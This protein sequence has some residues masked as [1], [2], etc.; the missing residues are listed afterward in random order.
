MKFLQLLTI[1]T[2]LFANNAYSSNHER[3]IHY[4]PDKPT[5]IQNALDIFESKLALVTKI[6]TKPKIDDY[7]MEDVHEI[8][9]SLESAVTYLIE[10]DDKR[11]KLLQKLEMVVLDLHNFSEER[12][13]NML[14]ISY[15]KVKVN[16]KKVKRSYGG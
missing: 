3:V 8:S 15:K 14:K 12:Q 13:L 11:F 6:M 5:S 16:Y 9:Y 10:N 2:V 1:I 4:S 7:D